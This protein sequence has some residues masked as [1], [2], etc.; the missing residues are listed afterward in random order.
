MADSNEI[1]SII[2]SI[3]SGEHTDTDIAVLREVLSSGDR[4]AIQLGKYNVNIGDGKEI[5]IGNRIYQ[6]WDEQAISAVVKAIQ[7]TT[8]KNVPTQ[9]QSLIADK[10]EGFVGREYVFDAI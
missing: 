9:F 10:T 3:A 8:P 2:D 7:Q 1:N 5:H 4:Q 6:Q